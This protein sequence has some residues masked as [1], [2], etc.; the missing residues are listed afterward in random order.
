MDTV[1][2]NYAAIQHLRYSES[3]FYAVIGQLHTI[4]KNLLTEI[5]ETFSN[6]SFVRIRR[7][8]KTSKVQVYEILR[9]NA[10]SRVSG[11]GV[12]TFLLFA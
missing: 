8:T 12:G 1:F 9:I 4:S 10:D 6:K 11:R 5:H 7:T 3:S 2:E